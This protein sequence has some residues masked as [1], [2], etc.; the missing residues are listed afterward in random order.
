MA[1]AGSYN[2]ANFQSNLWGAVS[3]PANNNVAWLKCA[4]FDTCKITPTSG[5]PGMWITA[6]YW[7]VQGWEVHM[8][9]DS[10]NGCFTVSPQYSGTQIEVH[11]VIIANNIANGCY[12][13]GIGSGFKTPTAGVDYL[14]VV[15]NIVYNAAAGSSV[16]QSGI[17]IFQ[18]VAQDTSAGTHIYIAG[19]FSYAN[20]N[21]NPCAGTAP[22]DGE[23]VILDTIQ[24]TSASGGPPPYTQ[25]IVVDN[26]ILIGNGG[27]GLE[28]YNSALGTTHAPIYFRYNTIW[29]NNTDPNQTDEVYEEE[30]SIGAALNVQEV[31][32][33]AATNA[34]SISGHTIYAYSVVNGDSSDVVNNNVGWSASGTYDDAITNSPA[35]SY[36]S[37][38]QFGLNPNFANPSVPS[39][40]SCSGYSNTVACMATVIADFTPTNATAKSYGYQQPSSTPNSDPLFPK[41]LCNVNLPSGLVTMGCLNATS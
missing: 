38:D 6:S 14:A 28:A 19:N 36:G 15:G 21:S 31:S 5:N 34:A 2:S 13:G 17:A 16:C 25:Q 33:I 30:S 24:G 7:G 27:R 22:T 39:A 29:G 37:G 41:W 40:P 23:G 1:A 20:V 8:T 9:A 12:E 11:H 26:N 35:F 3:C 10:Y 18:P 4:T 32:N